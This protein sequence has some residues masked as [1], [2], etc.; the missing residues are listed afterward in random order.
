M[1]LMQASSELAYG[2]EPHDHI[3]TAVDGAGYGVSGGSGGG[4]YPG[5]CG[6]GWVW[7]G[8]IPGTQPP[9]SPRPDSGLFNELYIKYGSYG[10]L[11]G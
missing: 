10:R 9:V 5:W 11:T 7:E 2:L 8:G 1:P 6:S 3:G 4:V